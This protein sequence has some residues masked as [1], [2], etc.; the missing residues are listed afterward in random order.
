MSIV[1]TTAKAKNWCD[2]HRGTVVTRDAN[3]TTVYVCNAVGSTIDRGNKT[4][5]WETSVENERGPRASLR[6]Q[7]CNFWGCPNKADVGG[8]VRVFKGPRSELI[9][10]YFIMPTCSS[11]NNSRLRD[12]RC[13]GLHPL[14]INYKL[15]FRGMALD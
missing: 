7:D 15:V 13:G 8:H 11:C 10:G 3:D 5:F 4:E 1:F 2:D 6:N 14:I 9:D 12:C